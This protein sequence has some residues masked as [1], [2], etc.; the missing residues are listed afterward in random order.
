MLTHEKTPGVMELAASLKKLESVKILVE[1]GVS[2]NVRK[3]SRYHP[4]I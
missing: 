4:Q 1:A 3:V 2:P